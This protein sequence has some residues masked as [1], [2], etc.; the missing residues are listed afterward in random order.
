MSVLSVVFSLNL[1]FIKNITSV[2]IDVIYLFKS[3]LYT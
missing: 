1:F 3:S 2:L